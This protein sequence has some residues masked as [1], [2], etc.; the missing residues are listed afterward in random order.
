[1]LT[2][3]QS[4]VPNPDAMKLQ[5]A[6]NDATATVL[7]LTNRVTVSTSMQS[8]V[9]ALAEVYY[10]RMLATGEESRSEGDV[11]ITYAYAKDIPEDLYKRIISYRKLKA[12]TMRSAT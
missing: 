12:A 9:V 11:D 3:L 5:E 2:R 4:R 8:V 1:M 10:Y 7:E 6:L